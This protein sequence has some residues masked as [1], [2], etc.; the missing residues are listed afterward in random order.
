M[1]RVLLRTILAI[2]LLLQVCVTV[3]APVF[4]QAY[5][6][7]NTLSFSDMEL[8]HGNVMV[9]MISNGSQYYV[10][11]YNTSTTIPFSGYSDYLVVFQPN[12]LTAYTSTANGPISFGLDNQ[13]IIGAIVLALLLLFAVYL[14]IRRY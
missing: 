9:W 2:L 8:F 6:D 12:T 13:Q 14:I 4:A 11:T 1:S 5:V 7:N 10:G 3:E